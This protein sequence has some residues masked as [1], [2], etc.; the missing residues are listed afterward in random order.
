MI[1]S[2]R[3]ITPELART[4]KLLVSDFDGTLTLAD[5]SLP[6]EVIDVVNRLERCGITVGLASGRAFYKLDSVAGELDINGLLIAENGGTARLKVGGEILD[7]GYSRKPALNALAKLKKA[8][9]D[10]IREREDNPDRL[11]DIVIYAQGLEIEELQRHVDDAQ[12]LY[13][14]YMIHLMQKG[15]SKGRTLMRLLGQVDRGT[16]SSQEVM[17]VGDSLTDMSLFEMFPHSVLIINPKLPVEHRQA[18]EKVARYT[19]ELELGHGF[20]QVASHILQA[21]CGSLG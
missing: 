10:S 6:P 19:G 5:G 21:R 3:E 20:A 9:P 15:I 14:G 4:I 2:Y 11:I 18:L 17:V 12:V 13:S 7:L 1:K 8:Y 16:L